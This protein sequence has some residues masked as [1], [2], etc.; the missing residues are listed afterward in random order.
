[1]AVFAVKP[2]KHRKT[3]R[4]ALPCP[5]EATHWNLIIWPLSFLF[6]LLKN[7]FT[8]EWG[9]LWACLEWFLVQP[10]RLKTQFTEAGFLRTPCLIEVVNCLT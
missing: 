4:W 8:R 7:P 10:N 5:T 9:L 3:G 1:M 2:Q 6:F